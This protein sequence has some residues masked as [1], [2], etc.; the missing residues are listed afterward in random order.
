MLFRSVDDDPSPAHDLIRNLGLDDVIY[1]LL[2]LLLFPRLSQLLEDRDLQAP[3]SRSRIFEELLEWIDA[4]LQGPIQ[5][6]ELEQVSGYSRR[7]LQAAFQ[8]RFGCG[9]IQWVRRQR[10]ERARQAL[11]QPDA[12]ETVSEIAGR[13][14]FSNLAVFSRD[15]HACFGL[16]P[17][18]LLREGRRHRS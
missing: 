3:S 16:R 4:N 17:S 5:L 13:F 11:L 18:D 10:L 8:Q 9:P 14:G 12:D 2:A 15:F 1:R 7:H 6:S